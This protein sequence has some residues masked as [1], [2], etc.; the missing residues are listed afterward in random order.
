MGL[1]T[2][3]FL[4]HIQ[5]DFSHGKE[6]AVISSYAFSKASSS[7]IFHWHLVKL[8]IVFILD[9]IKTKPISDILNSRSDRDTLFFLVNQELDKKRDQV[10]LDLTVI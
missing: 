2:S 7:A 4:K 5:C 3:P 1:L 10:N 8:G 9:Y 6:T